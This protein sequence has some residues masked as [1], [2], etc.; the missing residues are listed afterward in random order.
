MGSIQALRHATSST[1]MGPPCTV[2][3][4]LRSLIPAEAEALEAL[5]ADPAVRYSLIADGL[6]AEGVAD[7]EP[8]TLSRHA[9]GACWEM[10]QDG[11]RLR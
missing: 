2:C 1:R 10:R 9:R 4:L 6:R 5:L 8:R 11:R 3:E 7:F